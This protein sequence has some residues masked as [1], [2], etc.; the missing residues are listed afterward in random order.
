[1]IN[2]WGWRHLLRKAFTFFAWLW[3]GL[4][5]WKNPCFQRC[6]CPDGLL[7]D[8]RQASLPEFS[9]LR[10]FPTRENTSRL[11]QEQAEWHSARLCVGICCCQ[12]SPMTWEHFRTFWKY[13]LKNIKM[14]FSHSAII[15]V[16]IFSHYLSRSVCVCVCVCIWVCVC[17]LH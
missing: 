14:Q 6:T 11:G 17:L 10:T 1:M 13:R 8:W 5:H 4:S 9:A 15:T 3:A 2:I 16:I 12:S 7:R